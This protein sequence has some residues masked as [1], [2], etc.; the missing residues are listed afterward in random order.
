MGYEQNGPAYAIAKMT[1][2]ASGMVGQ[3]TTGSAPAQ[4]TPLQV[5]LEQERHAI[6]T[7]SGAIF[8]LEKR[9]SPISR[10]AG[11]KPNGSEGGDAAIPSP[12]VGAL[13]ENTRRLRDLA[14]VVGDILQ[15]L[16]C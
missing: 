10:Q 14:T 9:L 6:D 16:D 4:V 5:A 3:A 12:L 1:E 11:P 2:L 15:H 7:V 13:Y 8:E